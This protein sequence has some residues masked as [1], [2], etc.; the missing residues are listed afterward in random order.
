LSNPNIAN[1]I[2][3]PIQSTQ[4]YVTAT[5][6]GN[7][8]TVDSVLVQVRSLPQ[9]IGIGDTI[10][11]GETGLLQVSGANN[12]SWSPNLALSSTTGASVLANPIKTRTYTVIGTDAF[13][14]QGRTNITL[15]VGKK[16]AVNLG[17]DRKVCKGTLVTLDAGNSGAS[18]L[19][20]TGETSQLINTYN[21]GIYVVK[22][23]TALGCESRDTVVIVLKKCVF[24][25]DVF[26]ASRPT[27]VHTWEETEW[28]VYPNPHENFFIIE[29]GE[30]MIGEKFKIMDLLGRIVLESKIESTRNQIETGF[31]PAG[32]YFI[33]ME[34]RGELKKLIK[35]Q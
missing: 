2:A 27:D 31:W 24:Y 17:P 1:P 13:G 32:I 14:C 20:N 19:W 35:K 26:A 4:Y 18:F 16:P 15:I 34:S 22:V 21:P 30:D 25:P 5:G 33:Q 7:C 9:L 23:S 29:N 10:C 11:Q 8:Q 28:N 12:Y 6:N 3:S